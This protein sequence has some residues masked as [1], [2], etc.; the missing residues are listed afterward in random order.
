VESSLLEGVELPPQPES[1]S[2]A[3]GS[4]D[5]AA[6]LAAET[7][8][9]L[10]AA[11]QAVD[12]VAAEDAAIGAV[13]TQTQVV[14]ER[15]FDESGGMQLVVH[16]PF[17]GRINRAWG[18]AMRKRFCRSFDFELQATADDDGFILSLGPQHS[19][20]IEALFSMLR[21]DNVLNLLEQAIIAVPMFHLRWR[22]NATRSLQ[23]DRQRN[24]KKVPPAL[25][26][27]RSE[28]L[29]TA[30]FPKL[31]GCQE[32]HTGD[33]VIPD[34]PLVRQTMHDCLHEA[35]DIDGLIDVLER[36]ERGEI[37]LIARDTRE[38]SPFAYELLN[39]N[40][41]AF[42]DGGEIQERRARM[43]ATRRS[44]SVESV[45]D[46]GR[47]SPEAIE[48][49]V[50]ESQPLV[51]NADELH[52]VLLSRVYIPGGRPSEAVQDGG[53]PT[54]GLGRPSSEIFVAQPEWRLLF[55]ELVHEG[56][57]TLIETVRGLQVWVATERVPAVRALF[58]ELVCRPEVDVPS[59]VQQQWEDVEARIAVLRGLLEISGPVTAAQVAALTGFTGGQVAAGLE[60]L[61]GEG[62]VLRGRFRNW[63]AA[64]TDAP[65]SSDAGAEWCHRRLLARIHRLTVAGL[66]REI[67]P[68]EIADFI[69]FVCRHQGIVGEDRRQGAS[70]LHVVISQLQGLDIAAIAWERD[71]LPARIPGYRRDWLDEL[72]LNG[73]VGWGRL[74][75]PPRDPEK[76]RSIASI[77]RVVPISLFLREDAA[78]L[79]EPTTEIAT[80][81]MLTS[82]ARE[83]FELLQANGA[84]FATDIAMQLNL[85]PAHLDEAL[86]EL[87]A[88]GLVTADGFAGLRNLIRESAE[89]R[90]GLSGRALRQTPRLIRHR[91]SPNQIGRWSVW[92]ET[93]APVETQDEPQRRR[94]VVEQ[95]AWQ[96]LRR[97]GVIFKDLLQ[98]EPG[99]P[100]WWEL[101]QVYRKLEARGEIRGGRFV[102][103]VA[104]EQFAIGETVVALRRL[105]DERTGP[106]GAVREVPDAR[107]E[108]N[109]NAADREGAAPQSFVVISASDP[110]NLTGILD[111]GP[112]VP[113]QAGNRVVL[114]Q[115]RFVAAWDGRD[116]TFAG[117]CP[118]GI[119][120]RLQQAAPLTSEA[121]LS[122][123][124]PS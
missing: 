77:T 71:V 16:A 60:S 32:E 23:V 46:L 37:K 78:W 61:E 22:W 102:R 4:D 25:Q 90:S 56:R 72:C 12:Y 85:L 113:A 6:W 38:P 50:L 42:L 9:T 54:D 43:A 99:A 21:P 105:R 112:R 118:A 62:V 35:L 111:G 28:D 39:A 27:F 33:H 18:L 67:E 87:V 11:R 121:V 115:G 41:Y 70:G 101:V 116:W 88:R 114:H 65:L 81:E 26:R 30:V 103:G 100:P 73:E 2:S 57:A 8:C 122:L 93:S 7:N 40:P 83:V 91:R 74:Y 58:P 76:S 117:E 79:R 95:W 17:G 98:K 44:V 19:F 47:L 69:S 86:G 92:R 48:Q 64:T 107:A 96:L 5:L 108:T 89:Q 66:R 120:Q 45:R 51:R 82:T 31:T 13:P 15:F 75:P 55:H 123:A 109:V 97:W 94:E 3:H 20:P 10:E 80:I 84:T 36:I 124:G 34:H 63:D 68:V 110:L 49:V 52:D 29:L 106:H 119:R 104:G 1:V 59:T 14:F 24:G 53:T